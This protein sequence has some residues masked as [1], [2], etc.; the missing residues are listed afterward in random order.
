LERIYNLPCGFR[1]VLEY[2]GL[3]DVTEV[4]GDGVLREG[5]CRHQDLTGEEAKNL[6]AALKVVD[7]EFGYHGRVKVYERLDIDDEV[8]GRPTGD[9]SGIEI[10][11]SVL[12][13]LHGTVRV[14]LHEMVH[15][16]DGVGD[17]TLG[18]EEGLDS[19]YAV[20]ASTLHLDREC[21]A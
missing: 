5:Y 8:L 14:L 13:S 19:R 11:R 9:D 20:V 16:V 18:F 1:N 21:A 7:R 10:R 12:G 17:C 6:E 3:K 4:L 2:L 15:I